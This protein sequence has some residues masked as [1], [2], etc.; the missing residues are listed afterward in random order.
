MSSVFPRRALSD[1]DAVFSLTSGS[2]KWVVHAK[3]QWRRRRYFVTDFGRGSEGDDVSGALQMRDYDFKALSGQVQQLQP[4]LLDARGRHELRSVRVEG[5]RGALVPLLSHSALPP[6]RAPHTQKNASLCS[7]S[8]VQS[9]MKIV[10]YA[11]SAR[12]RARRAGPRNFGLLLCSVWPLPKHRA[13]ARPRARTLTLPESQMDA[14]ESILNALPPGEW[15]RGDKAIDALSTLDYVLGTDFEFPKEVIAGLQ[16]L[17]HPLLDKEPHLKKFLNVRARV[18]K[19]RTE[20]TS[21]LK[22]LTFDALMDLE[23]LLEDLDWYSEEGK[24]PENAAEELSDEGAELLLEVM[25]LHLVPRR[26]HTSF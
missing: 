16:F 4:L 11:S 17:A 19:V 13:A 10:D 9:L 21:G 22:Q 7:K 3:P 8:A 1:E 18:R 5:H 12:L 26:T 14:L 25:L 20:S 6:P 24:V 23:D 15:P 2:T